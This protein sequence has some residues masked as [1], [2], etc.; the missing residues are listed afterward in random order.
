MVVSGPTSQPRT[1]YL[2]AAPTLTSMIRPSGVTA[3]VPGV[4]STI[5][6]PF[7]KAKKSLVTVPSAV[8]VQVSRKASVSEPAY[9][10]VLRSTYVVLKR[11][12]CVHTPA[13]SASVIGRA[14]GG[15]TTGPPGAEAEAGGGGGGGGVRGP[16]TE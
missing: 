13:R 16:P 8:M 2:A 11:S 7:F 14:G 3:I 9:A 12:S 1:T 4:F 6:R 10:P 15:M 5:F